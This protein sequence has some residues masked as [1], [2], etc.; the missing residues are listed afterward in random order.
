MRLRVPLRNMETRSRIRP[1]FALDARIIFITLFATFP[2]LACQNASVLRSSRHLELGVRF[3]THDPRIIQQASRALERWSEIVDL[4]WHRD[5]S[6]NCSIDIK[7]DTFAEE[8]EVAESNAEEGSIIFASDAELTAKQLFVTAF[9][10]IGH[11]LGLQHNPSAHSVMYWIDFRGD[12]VLDNS[13]MHAL[14]TI[15]ALRSGSGCGGHGACEILSPTLQARRIGNK[16]Q[17][18]QTASAVRQ[19]ASLRPT[20]K[21]SRRRHHHSKLKSARA[22]TTSP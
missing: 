4:S 10:E 12:E 14:A 1:C 19:S 3:S 22:R 11:L 9:H 18:S 2:A 21:R 13:D 17:T 8:D 15:H 5:D 6:D 20:A 16:T 7:A